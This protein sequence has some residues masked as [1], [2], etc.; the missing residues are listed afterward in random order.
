MEDNNGKVAVVTGAAG[1][2]GRVTAGMF[3]VDGY[4]VL[5]VDLNDT[6]FEDGNIRFLRADLCPYDDICGVFEYAK[7]SFG[8]VH[9]LVNNGAISKFSKSIFEITP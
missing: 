8:G 3:A 5:A 9:V 7:R 2:I 4:T 1:G 6:V